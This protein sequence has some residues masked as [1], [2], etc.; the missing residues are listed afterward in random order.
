MYPALNSIIGYGRIAPLLLGP[1]MTRIIFRSWFGFLAMI[2]GSNGSVGPLLWLSVWA[3]VVRFVNDGILG[4]YAL[5][6]FQGPVC[7]FSERR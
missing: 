4:T 6:F 1:L 2:H 7:L 3:A 5:A